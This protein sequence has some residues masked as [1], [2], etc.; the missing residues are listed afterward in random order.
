MLLQP[1]KE[2]GADMGRQA[3]T[4]ELMHIH[5]LTK[6]WDQKRGDWDTQGVT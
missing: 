2:D 1:C 5:L 6:V 3:D 4:H